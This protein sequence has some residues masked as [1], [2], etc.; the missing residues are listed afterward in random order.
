MRNIIFNIKCGTSIF[1]SVK[2]Q[3][4]GRVVSDTEVYKS[5]IND[6]NRNLGVGGATLSR[7]LFVMKHHFKFHNNQGL[8]HTKMQRLLLF[9][10]SGLNFEPCQ[11]GLGI[12]PIRPCVVCVCD[13][14]NIY[15]YIE[16]NVFETLL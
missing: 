16:I 14:R 15:I 8:R 2:P 9:K 10:Q 13:N 7:T 11:W 5:T 3:V 6:I 4:C 1:Q 12:R